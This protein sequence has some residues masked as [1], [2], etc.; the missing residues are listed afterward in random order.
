[1]RTSPTEAVETAKGTG[2][3][4]EATA[5]MSFSGTPSETAHDVKTL[6]VEWHF[7]QGPADL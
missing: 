4:Q 7:T 5:Q 6:L 3:A 2:E 1:M